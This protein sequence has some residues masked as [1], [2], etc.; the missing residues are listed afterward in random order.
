MIL[1]WFHG[2]ITRRQAEEALLQLQF[3]GAFLIR[4]SESS[5]GTL[6]IPFYQIKLLVKLNQTPNFHVLK[7][8]AIW[9]DSNDISLTV[10]SEVELN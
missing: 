1:S 7:L 3:E 6:I 5:P 10:D 2:K 8:I 9:V 4:E